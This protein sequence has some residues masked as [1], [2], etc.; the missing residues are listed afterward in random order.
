MLRYSHQQKTRAYFLSA[1][2]QLPREGSKAGN[3]KLL[4]EADVVKLQAPDGG[5]DSANEERSI[6]G[7]DCQYPTPDTGTDA[8]YSPGVI[9][10]DVL[11][12][13]RRIA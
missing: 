4:T 6:A 10:R 3:V 13:D 8:R 1:R 11:G 9:A 2:L 7:D 5:L 12:R